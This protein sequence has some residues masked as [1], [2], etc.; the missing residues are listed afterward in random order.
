MKVLAVMPHLYNSAPGA[1]FRIEQWARYLQPQGFE[2]TFAAFQDRALHDVLYQPGQ[3]ARK[4]ALIAR[5]WLRRLQLV[6]QVKRYDLIFLHREAALVGPALIEQMMARRGVPIVYDFDDPIWLA[7]SSPTNARFS[8]FKWQSKVA[9]VCALAKQVIVGNRLLGEW[10]SQHARQVAIVPSTI[11]LNV[12]PLKPEPTDKRTITLGWTG[13]HSTLPFLQEIQ[14]VLKQLAQ[15]Y[16]FRLVVIS[17]TDALQMDIAPAQLI[18]QKWNADTEAT[19]LHAFDIGLAPFPNTGWTPW[20]CHGKVLQYMAVG[21]PTIA[22]SIGILPDYINDGI[23]GLLASTPDEWETKLAFLIRNRMM[24]RALGLAG[25][26]TIEDG[27]SAQVWAPRVQQL[28]EA[29]VA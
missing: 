25:R 10:A 19:D 4:G 22:S 9:Q 3:S 28:F 11:D 5:G 6:A 23:N 1:R 24:R 21:V 2:F 8:G 12:Y 17:H 16:S 26:R 13:S 29:A 7:Y 20:R 14:G 15:K 27:Y 18:S